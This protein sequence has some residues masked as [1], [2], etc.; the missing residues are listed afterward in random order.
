[1]AR[2][3]SLLIRPISH[4]FEKFAGLVSPLQCRIG[5]HLFALAAGGQ[6]LQRVRRPLVP[7]G[8]VSEVSLR[9]GVDLLG[10]EDAIAACE[11]EERDVRLTA[12]VRS[13]VLGL[14]YLAF[15]K[16]VQEI[17]TDEFEI[18]LRQAL[19]GDAFVSESF[20][21]GYS[22]HVLLTLDRDIPRDP[23][24]LDPS[25]RHTILDES[26]VE[27]GLKSE[28]GVSL[29]IKPLSEAVRSANGLGRDCWVFVESHE[30]NLAEVA[31]LAG[32]LTVYV[33][34][35]MLGR[36]KLSP[37]KPAS[38]LAIG[39]MLE[40]IYGYLVVTASK[41]IDSGGYVFSD[42]DGSL[43]ANMCKAWCQKISTVSE[44]PVIFEMLR[45]EPLRLLTLLQQG[46]GIPKTFNRAFAQGEE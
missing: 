41:E 2:E 38:R 8:G 31:E 13:T 34:E 37:S 27:I 32:V 16:T 19:V 40:H 4:R 15:D 7:L 9:V 17:D 6:R 28:G 20:L 35:S 29:D 1:M 12:F 18:D 11:L 45:Q 30:L 24:S 22:V 33:D 21:S 43:L 39:M 25:K 5:D 44:A 3:R 26:V 10:L 46:V 36:V 14:G 42:I 23:A